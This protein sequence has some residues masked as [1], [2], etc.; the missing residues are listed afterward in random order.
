[1]C[2]CY[3][4]MQRLLIFLLVW[5]V[6]LEI[7]AAQWFTQCAN[8]TTQQ[9]FDVKHYLGTWYD[10]AHFDVFFQ[11]NGV[12]ARAQYSPHEE[13]PGYIK[14][15]NSQR[16]NDPVSGPYDKIVGE[17]VQDSVDPAKLKVRFPSKLT[18]SPWAP[19]WVVETNYEDY[20]MVYS[21]S[22]ILGVYR[23]EA[24][25]IL[26][27]HPTMRKEM[28]DKIMA[29]WAKF[30]LDTSKFIFSVQEGCKYDE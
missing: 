17:A 9:N 14:V 11:R 8:V 27:R 7:C 21:C 20:A 15:K 22:N 12:C 13:K 16:L 28:I 29:K 19:Y 18:S 23:W 6:I 4:T 2:Q 25:W 3:Y 5:A 26:S 10:I 1:M 24:A 30:G